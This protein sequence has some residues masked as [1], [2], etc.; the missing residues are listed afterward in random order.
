[1][2]TLYD[3]HTKWL[4]AV[5]YEGISRYEE[6]ET[7]RK[8]I[9]VEIF[10]LKDMQE[11]EAWVAQSLNGQATSRKIKGSWV[12]SRLEQFLFLF[13]FS[14]AFR[15]DPRPDLVSSRKIPGVISSQVKATDA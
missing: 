10:L 6:Q 11:T 7:R 13:Y 3:G 2:T 1:M 8:Q 9:G 5:D 12:D 4:A 15:M 14:K